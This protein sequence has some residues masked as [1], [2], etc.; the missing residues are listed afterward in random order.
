M[1]VDFFQLRLVDVAAILKVAE[2]VLQEPEGAQIVVVLYAGTDHTRN[3][4]KF[5]RMQGFT[6]DGLPEAGWVG[7]EDFEDDELRAFELP[8]CL[9]TWSQ[10]FPVPGA[11][12]CRQ[13]CQQARD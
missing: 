3:V 4:E 12:K 1:L 8:P 6:A 2:L 11:E 13:A 9:N 10:L 7:K 5:W